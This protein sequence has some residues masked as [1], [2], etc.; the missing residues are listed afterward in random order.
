MFSN[1]SS[2]RRPAPVLLVQTL[3]HRCRRSRFLDLM[4]PDYDVA[5]IGAGPSGSYTA[6]LLAAAGHHVALLERDAQAGRP[7]HCTG[8]VSTECFERYRMPRS[9]VIREV[10]SFLLRSP[11]GRGTRIQRDTV[12][13]Y[14]LDRVGLDQLFVQR[15]VDAGASI[16][17]NTS[18]ED[19]QW[20][21][22]DVILQTFSHG[23]PHQLTARAAVMATGYGA[24]LARKV[25]MANSGEIVSGCQAVV[26][27]DG[28]DEVEVFTGRDY[29]DGGYGWL[30]PWRPGYALAGLLTR[31]HTV[32]YMKEHID[33]LQREGRIGAVQQ[34]FRCRPI[35]LSAT[36]RAVANG[37]LGVGDA[38]SQVKPTSGG[39]IYFGLLGAGAAASVLMSALDRGDLSAA[40]LA[41]YEK[42]WRGLMEPEVRAGY[43]LRRMLEQMP[44]AVVEAIHRLLS[45][46]GFAALLTSSGTFDWHSGPLTKVLSHFERYIQ[47]RGV[48]VS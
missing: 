32:R 30:V 8:I 19:V 24:P 11:S 1:N 9:L 3:S 7:V 25:G 18:V 13:A 29:G 38:V 41:A 46:P 37:I 16:L 35:P 28:V 36:T 39:G 26:R 34:V 21:G 14:V 33:R 15:A 45:V 4:T 42:E 20:T 5:V 43:A 48:T 10:D 47:V 31:K 12:Q 44:D 27:A 23:K 2:G 40:G 17:L 6:E 22:R